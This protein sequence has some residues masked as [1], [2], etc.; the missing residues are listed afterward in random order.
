MEE[1]CSKLTMAKN[2]TVHLSDIISVLAVSRFM[3]LTK[4]IVGMAR[5]EETGVW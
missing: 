5:K 2:D 3:V 4:E 1:L